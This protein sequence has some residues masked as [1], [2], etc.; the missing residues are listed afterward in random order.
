[1]TIPRKYSPYI[2]ITILCIMGVVLA[3]FMVPQLPWYLYAIGFVARF[4][5]L[6]A[7][8]Q[9]IRLINKRLEKRFTIEEQPGIQ[10]LLQVTVTL[11][12]ISPVFILSYLYTRPHLRNLLTSNEKIAPL[13]VAIYILSIMMMTFGY[14]AY[15]LFVKHKIASDEKNRLEREASQLEKEK[16]MMRYHHLKNQVNPHF[17][18]NT[19]SSLDGLIHSNPSLASDFVKHI[20][21]V[22]RYV[23]EHKENEVVSLETEVNF[24]GH[25][26]SLLQIRYGNGIDIKLDISEAGMEKGIAMVTLQMLIDNAVKHNSTHPANPLRIC[27]RDEDDYLYIHNNKQLRRQMEDTGKQG[28]KQL[29]ELYAFLTNQ[30]VDIT[31][32]ADSFEV[33]LPLL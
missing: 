17:L 18:F 13:I 7:I 23:L 12:L 29:K 24:I 30:P 11:I 31:E 22:Y 27:I 20:S 9:L 8:W 15:N 32:E 5:F 14:Y 2:F 25:Y 16:T 28:L 21:K 33:K 26:I 6:S 3:L 4:A 1:M 19:L 10:I